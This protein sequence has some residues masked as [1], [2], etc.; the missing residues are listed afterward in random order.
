MGGVGI[1]PTLIRQ[2]YSAFRPT[3]ATRT[4]K[5]VQPFDIGPPLEPVK[6]YGDLYSADS[7][8]NQGFEHPWWQEKLLEI[9]PVVDDDERWAIQAEM[10]RWAF[11]NAMDLPAVQYQPAMAPG[12]QARHLGTHGIELGLAELVGVRPPPLISHT[13]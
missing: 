10:A 11:D 3:I 9:R 13:T 1:R 2:T 6:L 8:F 7:G 5:G 12:P 4:G